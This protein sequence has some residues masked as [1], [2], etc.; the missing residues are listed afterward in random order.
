LPRVNLQTGIEIAILLMMG[1]IPLTWFS[2]DTI[3]AKGDA[4]PFWL[5]PARTLWADTHTWSS[6]NLGSPNTFPTY[7]LYEFVWLLLRSLGLTTGF[8][9]MLFQ[10]FY[11]AGSGLFMYVLVRTIYPELDLAALVSGVFYMFNFFVLEIMIQNV[12]ISWTYTFLPL[13]LTLLI[14]VIRDGTKNESRALNKNIF[15]FALVSTIT[16]SF[17]SQN[18]ANIVLSVLLLGVILCYYLFIEKRNARKLVVTARLAIVTI[19]F[20]FWW[21]I[22]L[23]NYYILSPL[24]FSEQINVTAWSWTH[25]KASFLNLF[26]LNGFWGWRPEYYPFYNSYSNPILILLT[27]IPFLLAGTALLFKTKRSLLN[28]Y[29]MLF[30]LIFLF[31]AKGLH[32]PLGPLNLLLYTYLPGMTMFREPA[33]KFTM[34]IVPFVA[35]LIGYAVHHLANARVAKRVP[36]KFSRLVVVG[37]FLFVLVASAYPLIINPIETKTPQLP[38]SS[39]IKIPDYWYEASDWLNNQSDWHRVL[40]TPPDDFYQMPYT[41]GY[42]G[43]DFPTV[44]IQKPVLL[45]LDSYKT[46]ASTMAT[47][48]QLYD[49]LKFNRTEEFKVFLDLL[50][51]K[52]I[53]QRNDILWN[54]SSR[55]IISPSAMQTFLTQ[56]AYIHFVRTFGQLN[57]YEY[58][59]VKPYVYVTSHSALQ[60]ATINIEPVTLLERSWNFTDPVDVREWQNATAPN[61]WQTNY[62]ITQDGNTLKAEL[63][64]STWGWK[65][66]SSPLLPAEYGATY[67]IQLDIKGQNA[68]QVHIKLAEYDVAKNVLTADYLAYVNDGTFNWTRTTFNFLPTNQTTK[69]LQIQVW[70]GHE[71]DKPYPNIIW[72]DNVKVNGHTTRLNTTGLGLIFHN[73]TQNQPATILDYSR[74]NPTKIVATINA[75]Q[76]FILAVSE[77]LDQ[78]WK[79]NVNGKQIENSPLYL[80]L[81]GFDIN[82]TGLLQVTIEYEPQQWFLYGSIIS[83]TS[84]IFCFAYLVHSFTKNKAIMKRIKVSFSNINR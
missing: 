80:G 16:F 5:N 21:M 79:A 28:A 26:W 43:T 40:V 51:I 18:P 27:F 82:Q 1:A 78:S 38:F 60:Q 68:H 14:K 12:A 47:L 9:Q 3:A 57:I 34:T 52:F 25:G 54:F 13:L 67:Q 41:W 53:V 50:S 15:Y 11:S 61:Q 42:Y 55:N 29:L 48:P 2:Q 44:L 33:S 72:V 10:I 36:T 31:L 22:P 84:V 39:F 65:T 46:S 6:L 17:S 75:T 56:Q 8:T 20:N 45:G 19:F 66:I 74:V 49:S 7:L 32:E 69:Y 23:I 76:P 24:T 30:I 70:H 35:V 37:F 63:W 77:A 71:T 62:T 59:D 83:A 64:N 58:T 73:S 81:K 4:F